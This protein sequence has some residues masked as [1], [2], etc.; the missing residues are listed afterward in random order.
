VPERDAPLATPPTVFVPEGAAA[1]STVSLGDEDA[2]HLRVLRLMPGATIR[3]VDGA[4]AVYAL[5]LDALDRRTARA[6]VTAREPST[7]EPG[8]ALWIVQAALHTAR[9]DWLVEKAA[10]IGVA[11]IVVARSERSQHGVSDR[12]VERWRRIARAATLQSMGARVPSI[13][14][15][16]SVKKGI[17]RAAAEAVVLADPDGGPTES[18]R[19]IPGTSQAIV[20]GPEG[21]FTPAERADLLAGGALPVSL[22]RRRLRAETAAVVLAASLA[23][24]AD[25]GESA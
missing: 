3:G 13:E 16:S 21:G 5:T 11:G 6:T 24:T 18:A 15:S 17:E 10:E 4:G 7:C 22:G 25:T 23:A 2:R 9:M 8:V 20:V 12:A 14:S 19:S 1:G